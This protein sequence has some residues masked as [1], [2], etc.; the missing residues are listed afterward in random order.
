ML[1][2]ASFGVLGVLM[3]CLCAR[4]CACI[5]VIACMCSALSACT[6]SPQHCHPHRRLH[7]SLV[8][9]LS[10]DLSLAPLQMRAIGEEA[11]VQRKPESSIAPKPAGVSAMKMAFERQEA[12]YNRMNRH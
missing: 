3:A 6:L 7:S 1:H 4:V 9:R 8:S 5:H 10:S 11:K 2:L 12:L